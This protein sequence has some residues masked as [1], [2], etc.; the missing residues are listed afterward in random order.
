MKTQWIA[1]CHFGVEAVLKR[2]LTDLGFEIDRVEDGRVLFSG[3]DDAGAR[4]NL[5]LRSAER[6]LF[7]AGEFRAETF[8]EL[9]EGTRAIPWEDY[10]PK[11]A[12][13]WVRKAYSVK[14]EL[15][16][17]SDIQAIMKK[18]MVERMRKTYR[19]SWFQED[20]PAYPL[21]VSI[22]KNEVSVGI[23]TS[24]DSLHK[25]GYRVSPVIAPLS[26]TLAASLILLSPWKND[27]IFVDPFCG[28]GTF[29]IEA[30]M[31]ARGIAPGANRSFLSEE[32]KTILP[33]GS[34][35]R[36]REEAAARIR[37]DVAADIQAYDI[38]ERAVRF[39]RENARAA[40]VDD[41]IHFQERAVKDLSHKKPYGF[42][43]ANPPY[44]ERLDGEDLDATYRE[45]GN[46]FQSLSDWS[47]FLLTAHEGA[48]SLIG[49][50]ADRKRKIYNGMLKTTLY[51]FMGGRPPKRGDHHGSDLSVH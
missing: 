7:H 19:V 39:A 48:E 18:A 11:N 6:V 2:E 14:S 28:S 37:N 47:L 45:L 8:D 26:E 1:P 50:K 16:S 27:R 46:A 44:G 22:R 38:D 13:F 32:W 42:L 17:P 21:R 10:L 9:F 51:Q 24:G 29:P 30:A 23:D 31:I 40:G 5:H 4:A 43:F 12:K 3:D 49:R 35:K 41:L 34:F 25:R 33:R 15:F 36:A 20:G